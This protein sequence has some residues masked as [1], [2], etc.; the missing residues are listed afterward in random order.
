M[1]SVVSTFVFFF[2]LFLFAK[3]GP[4]L[5][6]S[7]VSQQRGDPFVVQGTGKV[8]IVPNV[9]RVT[10]G[11]EENGNTLKNTQNSANKKS[12]D[13]VESLR[14]LGVGESNIKTTSYNIFPEYNYDSQFPRITG[15]R[16]SINYEVKITDFDKVDDVLITTTNAGANVI[17]GISFE[18]DEKTKKEKLQEARELAIKEAK[19]KAESLAKTAG[20]SLGKVINVSENQAVNFPQPFMSE[21]AVALP[22]SDNIAR[23]EI[24]PG[25]TEIS[26]NVS[27]SFEVK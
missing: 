27:L 4:Y 21:K 11:I 13:L 6:I 5:P 10:V 14:K 16:V 24:A 9:V 15:Y 17:G 7:V 18:L 23:P 1:K 3:F 22:N 19:E 25:E 12:K 26:V 8:T 2:L 20:I